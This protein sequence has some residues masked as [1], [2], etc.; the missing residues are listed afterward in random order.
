MKVSHNNIHQHIFCF[1]K[2]LK[3]GCVS[4]K[5][6]TV[7]FISYWW[8]GV[9][10]IIEMF[11]SVW[12]LILMAPIHCR[13]Y[14]VEVIQCYISPDLMKKPN[15]SPSRRAWGWPWRHVWENYSFKCRIVCRRTIA[16]SLRNI[17]TAHVKW[18]QGFGWS[19][20]TVERFAVQIVSVLTG[21]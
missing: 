12:T 10:W 14:I 1:I 16:G 9:V 4:Y 6:A 5:H 21:L 3:D 20:D 11:L 17:S 2:H 8:T 18:I 7:C 15:S 19:Y 13:A